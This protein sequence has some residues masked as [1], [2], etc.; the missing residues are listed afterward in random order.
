MLLVVWIMLTVNVFANLLNRRVF[1]L[2]PSIHPSIRLL[3]ECAYSRS[4]WARGYR[5]MAGSH[6]PCTLALRPVK[7]WVITFVWS[8]ITNQERC[9]SSKCRTNISLLF[10]F[11]V[12]QRHLCY[13]FTTSQFSAYSLDVART[14]SR[15]RKLGN[16]HQ[17]RRGTS[18]GK[19][20]HQNN[21][22]TSS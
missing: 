5:S 13:S 8:G 19:W 16:L 11:C 15:S 6:K 14:V 20:A 4:G 12:A 10:W 7:G 1:L 17:R 9:C 21:P 18:R 22:A 3:S 2:H